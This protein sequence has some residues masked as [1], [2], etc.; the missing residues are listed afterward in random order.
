MAH[1]TNNHTNTLAS[2][3]QQSYTNVTAGDNEQKVKREWDCLF[4]P[5]V[6]K[7]NK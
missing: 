2:I 7:Y 1:N 4:V 6:I 5:L 3:V